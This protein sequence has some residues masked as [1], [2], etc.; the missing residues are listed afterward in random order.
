MNP[1]SPV[2]LADQRAAEI[3]ESARR[4]FA[5]KG[6]DGAS[7][8]D[9]ARQAGMSVGNFYRYFPSKSAIVEALIALD[10][11]EMEQDFAAILV[12]PE[13]IAALRKTIERKITD[14]DCQ[15]D[16]RIWAEITAASL[17]KPEIGDAACRM[18]AEIV[19]HLTKIFALA[20]GLS[21]EEAQLRWTAHAHL[22]VMLVKACAMQSP[23]NPVTA[24]LTQ[25]VMRNINQTLDDIAT[26]DAAKG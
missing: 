10:M 21:I 6:F 20:S 22:L 15:G 17:R 1:Q 12:H 16:G 19:V 9:I 2:P 23:E 5:E 14:S 24:D 4:A 25:L 11:A 3:L 18:E 26:S 8:Q 7:M 13:P